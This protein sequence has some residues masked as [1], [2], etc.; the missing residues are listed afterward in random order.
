MWP[1][2]RTAA[3]T[4]VSF[5]AEGSLTVYLFRDSQM[6]LPDSKDENLSQEGRDNNVWIDAKGEAAMSAIYVDDYLIVGLPKVVDA[7]MATLQ[8]FGRQVSLYTCPL[9]SVSLC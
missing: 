2:E 6:S 8:S 7:F 4:Q 5:T 3:M 9:P 1:E